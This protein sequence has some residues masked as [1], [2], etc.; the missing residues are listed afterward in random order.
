[1]VWANPRSLTTTYGITFIFFSYGYLNISIPHVR[2]PNKRDDIPSVYRV[3]PFG[4][5]RIKGHLHL[6]VA[7]RSLSRPSSLYRDWETDR[8]STRLNSSH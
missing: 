4:N 7:Y 5:P 3:T 6:P 8:K 2:L 1:M